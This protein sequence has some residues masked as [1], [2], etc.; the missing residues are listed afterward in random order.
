M[1]NFLEMEMNRVFFE[2]LTSKRDSAAKKWA[3]MREQNTF[4]G[5]ESAKIHSAETAVIKLMLDE[6]NGLLDAYWELHNG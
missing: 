1:L 2:L 5:Q 6:M 4:D 3:A